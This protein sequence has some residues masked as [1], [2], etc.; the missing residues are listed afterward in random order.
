MRVRIIG[1]GD[2]LESEVENAQGDILGEVVDFML[3]IEK[4]CITYVILSF[5]DLIAG[6]D[7]LYPI[8]WEVFNVDLDRQALLL[9]KTQETLREAP[10]FEAEDWPNLA[11]KRLAKELNAFYLRKGK[12]K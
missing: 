3:D 2:L 11:C 7:R 1:M 10:S 12:R 6:T 8:P 4:G 9:D 5:T